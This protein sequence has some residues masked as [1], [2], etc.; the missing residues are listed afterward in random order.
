[1]GEKRKQVYGLLACLLVMSLAG[2]S[3]RDEQA[4]SAGIDQA[5][6]AAVVPVEVVLAERK[7][8]AVSKTYSGTLEGEEQASI[9]P[10]ISERIT[11]V[12]VRVG[13]SVRAGDLII[14]LDRSGA[15]SQYF[16]A[17]A[18]YRNAEK[19]LQR[20]KS[21]YKEGAISLQVL[22]GSQTAYDVSKANFDA[23]RS[24]VDLTT[25]IAGVVTAINGSA[26]DLAVPGA[27]LATVARIDRLKVIFSISESDV[28]NLAVGQQVT[29]YSETQQDARAVGK[30]IQLSKSADIR[31]RSFEIKAM[32]ANTPDKWFKPGMFCKAD[33]QLAPSSAG[34]VIPNAAIQSDGVS[35]RVYV[36]RDGRAY[37]HTVRVG[38]TD[39]M[40]SEILSGLNEHDTV[41]TTGATS[42]KDSGFVN[43]APSGEPQ[44]E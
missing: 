22:D 18:S 30:I 16:Q 13:Q 23:A 10:K 4:A 33:V 29:V 39:G 44:T 37:R 35:S 5:R 14:A 25:P 12:K 31:S 9:I 17:E 3:K 27:A 32:F 8:L 43:I 42:V 36:V 28:A 11:A 34:I 1:M 20:M 19:T 21:L 7:S 40:V 6:E 26:G 38:V 24:T 15:S 2:C 41:V